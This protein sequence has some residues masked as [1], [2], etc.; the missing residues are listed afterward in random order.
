MAYLK[1]WL[2]STG[3][4]VLIANINIKALKIRYIREYGKPSGKTT[5]VELLSAYIPLLIPYVN[6]LLVITMI[7]NEEEVYQKVVKN[8]KSRGIK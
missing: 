7:F 1:I 5:F 8:I 2:I 3:I 4:V 6:I